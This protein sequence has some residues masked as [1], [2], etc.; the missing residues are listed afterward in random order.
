MG[1][2]ASQRTRTAP[3]TGALRW[4]GQAR[5]YGRHVDRTGEMVIR[6]QGKVLVDETELALKARAMSED[7]K[8]TMDQISRDVGASPEQVAA[9]ERKPGRQ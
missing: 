6:L 8:R 7:F 1:K 4:E 5:C 9:L 2:P 3:Q